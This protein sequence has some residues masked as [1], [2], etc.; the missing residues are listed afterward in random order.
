[1]RRKVILLTALRV[2]DD[3][4][5]VLDSDGGNSNDGDGFLLRLMTGSVGW[6]RLMGSA[7]G[8]VV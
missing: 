2:A 1:M 6:R 4:F 7:I 3:Q 5:V 8:H